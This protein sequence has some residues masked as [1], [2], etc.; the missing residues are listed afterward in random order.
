VAGGLLGLV[1]DCGVEM[2]EFVVSELFDDVC[3]ER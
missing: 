2:F 3:E 1:M